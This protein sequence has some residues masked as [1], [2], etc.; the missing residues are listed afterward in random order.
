[1]KLFKRKKKGLEVKREFADNIPNI[2]N[3]YLPSG[4]GSEYDYLR[5]GSDFV[6][7]YTFDV[8]PRQIHAGWLDDITNLGNVVISSHIEPVANEEVANMIYSQEVKAESQLTLDYQKGVT[9]RL[10]IL[11]Q[12]VADYKALRELVQLGQDRIYYCTIHVAVY[13][14]TY[15]E[16]LE[17]C[18]QLSS[19]LAVRGIKA[20][21]AFMQQD[22][23]LKSTLPFNHNQ[24]ND[25]TRN[26]TSGAA[27]CLMPLTVSA[28]GHST[29]IPIG[30][31]IF[32]GSL[33]FFDRFAGEAIIPNQHLF[34]FGTSG[35][36]KS[37]TLRTITLL[38]SYKGIKALFIDPEGENVRLTL[39]VGGQIITIRPGL[40]SG[41]NPF[42][43]E[44]E[45]TESGE[46]MVNIYDKIED[47]QSLIASVYFYYNNENIDVHN[48]TILE[49]AI[50]ELYAERGINEDPNSL[51]DGNIK[52][53]LPTI[54]DLYNK[55]LTKP[56][57]ESIAQVV[58]ILTSEG[59]VGM[60]DGQSTIR[61]DDSPMI[62]FNLRY[63]ANEF[64]K[65]VGI[66]AILAWAWQ[67][68]AQRGGKEVPKSI[69]IDE[70]WMFLKYP[71]ATAYIEVLARRGRKHGCGLILATQEY[72]DFAKTPEGEAILKQC[73]SQFIMRQSPRAADVVIENLGLSEGTREYL[74][75]RYAMMGLGVLR[76][77]DSSTAI[78]IE[79]TPLE[80]EFVK[81]VLNTGGDGE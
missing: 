22:K 37:T 75:G 33:T 71:A 69:A 57:G 54:T 28:T 2:H 45:F 29:G 70:A 62:C 23:A 46:R 13:A 39:K 27:A 19:V 17:K 77:V 16:L 43:V 48:A 40:F 58:K 79:P 15:E 3:I 6:R 80:L 47:I 61:I 1:M 72:D 63:L 55:L 76:V 74:C 41:I 36:G 52:K 14:T 32:S 11:E 24:I 50:F 78:R 18:E 51:Y 64:H 9:N 67:K 25:Y 31:N 81:T 21:I 49:E 30:R 7:F 56:K 34:I 65:F 4:I 66:Q 38:E 26:L 60:F 44:P 10:A 5:L 53:L 59:S 73:A 42:D 68:F 35:S 8:Y 20:R 12:Q